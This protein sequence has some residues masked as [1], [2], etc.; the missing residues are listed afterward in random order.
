M[1][2]LLNEEMTDTDWDTSVISKCV[3]M[4]LELRISVCSFKANLPGWCYGSMQEHK[5]DWPATIYSY[6][7]ASAS[8]WLRLSLSWIVMRLRFD[9][10]PRNVGKQPRT[11]FSQHFIRAKNFSFIIFAAPRPW[12]ALQSAPLGACAL[13]IRVERRGSWGPTAGT[14][15]LVAGEC[16]NFL[17]TSIITLLPILHFAGTF[18]L[19]TS[20]HQ[21]DL[22]TD[23]ALH[24]V[25]VSTLPP[26]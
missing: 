16:C 5:R 12:P 8:L 3:R 21:V 2:L 9:R 17:N 4:R 11:Y 26:S 20:A 22:I 15:L 25:L 24:D 14:V 1:I 18:V 19:Q 7:Q 6:L 23:G 10:W 13:S